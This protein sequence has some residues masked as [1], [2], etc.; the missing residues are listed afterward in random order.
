MSMVL[1]DRE[2]RRT[3]RCTI[4]KRKEQGIRNREFCE[5]YLCTWWAELPYQAKEFALYSMSTGVEDMNI[6][7]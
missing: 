7:G 3:I 6:L 1:R 5:L 2:G 4:W